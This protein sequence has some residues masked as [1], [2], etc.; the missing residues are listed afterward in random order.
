[1]NTHPIGSVT[2]RRA[3]QRVIIGGACSLVAAG[4]VAQPAGEWPTK[5]LRVVCPFAPGGA[6]DIFARVLAQRLQAAFGQNFVVDNRGG[7]GGVIGTDLVAKAEPD[8][9]TLVFTSDSPITIGPNLYKNV[10]YDSLKDLTPIS[11][12]VS[13]VNV[14]VA[15][16]KLKINTV[17]DLLAQAK[18]RKAPFTYASSGTGA[19]GHLT[20]EL[21]RATTGI[22]LTHVPYKGGGPGITALIGGE[23]DISFATYPSVIPHTKS[24]RLTLVA[25]S[26]F[27]R[28]R[29][30]PDTPTIAESGVPGFGVDNWQGLLAPPKMPRKIAI[31]LNNEIAAIAKTKEFSDV[32]NG[33]GAE[34][35]AVGLE[36]FAA[37]IRTD[38]ARWKKIIDTNQI[39]GE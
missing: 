1:M 35:D 4:A 38:F 36:A 34:A 21:F 16:P 9:Y 19:F 8:G 2:L 3:V 6:T 14:L 10:P 29:L 20:G 27:K 18:Q 17:G 13:V 37:F 24:G 12:V 22:E 32:V 31:A 28:S 7:A 25:V 30:L 23:T 39:R 11:K 26:N 15:N 33:Q 5:T